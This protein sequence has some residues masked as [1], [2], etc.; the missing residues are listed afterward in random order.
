MIDSILTSTKKFC[1]IAE[2]YEYFDQDIIMLINSSVSTLYQLGIGEKGFYI[3]DKNTTW[4]DYL[5][6]SSIVHLVKEYIWLTVKNV[7]DPPAGSAA[8]AYKDKITEL[9]W[10]LNIQA[11]PKTNNVL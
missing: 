4:Q 2:D 11:D 5:G 9:T 10:R 8:S 6:D 1:N 3:E 7:F